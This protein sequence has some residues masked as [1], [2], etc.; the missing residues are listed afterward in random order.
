MENITVSLADIKA[1]LAD[2][3]LAIQRYVES[4]ISGDP[5]VMGMGTSRPTSLAAKMLADPHIADYARS[6]NRLPG[7]VS[8][9]FDAAH[10]LKSTITNATPSGG[11]LSQ[12]D[13][14]PG[15]LPLA[16][17]RRWIWDA[18]FTMG[19]ATSNVVEYLRES[20]SVRVAGTQAN[21]GAQKP[22][23]DFT[24][25]LETAPTETLAHFTKASRQAL[26]D[27]PALDAF[28]R[29]RL[30][31]GIWRQLEKRIISGAPGPNRISGL[32][33]VGSF[34]AYAG[35]PTR[36]PLDR[37]RD[38]IATLQ[39]ADYQP[40]L[41][42]LHPNDWAALETATAGGSQEY[43]L[44][45]PQAAATPVL[46]GVPIHVSPDAVPGDFVLADASNLALWARNE[47]Q[48]LVSDSDGTDFTS[49]VVTLLA[50]A[51]FAFAS[52]RPESVLI[53]A[54]DGA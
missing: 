7:R 39:A 29:D 30:L 15:I 12:N 22:Q 23:A 20:G 18:G 5:A 40:T 46:W 49:N 42:L 4:R 6:S 36:K 14:V 26:S 17:R 51:R 37:I 19:T 24:F 47:A 32:Y 44:A 33:S 8:V 38:A 21:E 13:R 1:E 45:S 35:S 34:T 50:E 41:L 52:T 27:Q 28:L 25:S 11:S 53:G 10:E 31:Q 48:I 9:N 3:N 43:L 2:Q 54:L 16:S